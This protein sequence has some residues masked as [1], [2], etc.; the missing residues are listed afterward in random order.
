MKKDEYKKLTGD[1]E[2]AHKEYFEYLGSFFTS[3]IDGIVVREARK[4]LTIVEAEK[5][6]T[7]WNNL[8]KLHDE[9]Y[10]VATSNQPLGD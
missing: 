9:L 8:Q 3:T 10:K 2:R 1:L 5:L 4:V 7:M 6:R